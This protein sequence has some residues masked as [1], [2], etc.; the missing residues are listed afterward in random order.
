[1]LEGVCLS[2]T[3]T[4]THMFEGFASAASPKVAWLGFSGDTGQNRESAKNVRFQRQNMRL[5]TLQNEAQRLPKSFP[6]ASWRPKG[7][8]GALWG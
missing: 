4:H 7:A 2:D 3:P 5:G 8:P 6:E 1:M